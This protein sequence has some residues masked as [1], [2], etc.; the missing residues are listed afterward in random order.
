MAFKFRQSGCGVHISNH[1]ASLPLCVLPQE[2]HVFFCVSLY[3]HTHQILLAT[4]CVGVF[5][6]KQFCNSLSTPS[7][8]PMIP[9]N[10]STIYLEMASDPMQ[11]Q[12][13]SATRL[14]PSRHQ[15]QVQNVTCALDP[16]AISQ[17]FLQP[18]PRIPSFP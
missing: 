16:P 6:T 1:T 4:I 15:L 12:G 14:C 18:P 5:P 10:S 8:C 11:L 9:F 7:G 17:W 3:S 2:R 13:L